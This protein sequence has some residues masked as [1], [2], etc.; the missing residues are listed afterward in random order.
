[1][2]SATCINEHIRKELNAH[3]INMYYETIYIIPSH[4]MMRMTKVYPL[5]V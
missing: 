2:N 3:S 1:M 4:I 5:L